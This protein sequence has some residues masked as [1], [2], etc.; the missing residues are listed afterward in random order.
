MQEYAADVLGYRFQ[1]PELLEEALTH[2][3]S[4][5]HRLQ[6]NERLEFLGDA[7]LGFVVCEYI[8]SAFPELLEGELTK[9]KSA[10]VSR[11]ICAL[12]SQGLE[13]VE[14]LTLGKGMAGRPE[15]PSSIAAAVFESVIGAMYLDGG[16]DPA[17][18][19]ILEHVRPYIDEAAASAHQQ[20]FKSV[21]QQYAQRHLPANPAYLLLDEKGPDHAKA[22]EVCVEL[23]GRRHG[24]AWA[25]SKKEAE[26]QAALI[27]LTELGLADVDDEGRVHLR[28]AAIDA[29]QRQATPDDD[30]QMNNV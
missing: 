15:L 18:R 2:A 26:Q 5:G 7:V 27:A 4:A 1:N 10:V 16:L 13:L 12:I 28:G 22:F 11:R 17:R 21:L 3:S 29:A 24:S 25:N 9:I 19:F 30:A 20:N 23:Q 8:F 6:S 14:R